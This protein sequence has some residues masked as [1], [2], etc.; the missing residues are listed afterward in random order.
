MI[1]LSPE[2]AR[3]EMPIA[4]SDLGAALDIH[5]GRDYKGKGRDDRATC[6]MQKSNHRTT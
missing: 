2:A 6:A 1:Q 4:A 3:E 5:G